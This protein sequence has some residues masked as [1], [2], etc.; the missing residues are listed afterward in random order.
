M[1][2][3]K[4]RILIVDDSALV[5]QTLTSI[6]SS[7]PEIEVIAADLAAQVFG[8]RFPVLTRLARDVRLGGRGDTIPVDP[9]G[10]ARLLKRK[11]FCSHGVRSCW[12]DGRK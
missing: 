3:K 8:A 10:P 12:P 6:Y 2:S 11:G 9:R 5:R 4:I 7:D 1:N